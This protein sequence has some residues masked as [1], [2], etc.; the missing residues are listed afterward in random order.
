M[1]GT[2]KPELNDRGGINLS[3][4]TSERQVAGC[5][6]SRPEALSLASSILSRLGVTSIT[7]RPDG[8]WIAS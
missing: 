8:T 3:I 2:I 7:N 5:S 4:A 6:L 1:P